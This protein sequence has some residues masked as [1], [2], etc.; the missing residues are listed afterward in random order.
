MS[1]LVLRLTADAT[2]RGATTRDGLQVFSVFDCISLM[3]QKSAAYSR[4]IWKRLISDDSDYKVE[5]EALVYTVTLRHSGK[6]TS[7][8]TPAMTLRGLQRLVMILR[9]KRETPLRTL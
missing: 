1:D 2:V 8:H 7:Y 9:E 6:H 5:L 4:Q 3:C